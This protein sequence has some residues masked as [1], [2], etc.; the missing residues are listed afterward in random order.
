M[1]Y[2][3][4]FELSVTHAYY[5]DARCP[6]FVIEAS[7][8]TARLLKNHRLM[9]KPKPDG[10]KVLA[11]VDDEGRLFLPLSDTAEFVFSL[12]LQNPDFALFTDLTD[13]TGE[14]SLRFSNATLG[15]GNTVLLR[16]S[17]LET[18]TETLV[19]V[20]P[21]ENEPFMLGGRPLKASRLEDF[22]VSGGGVVTAY[23]A[24]TKGVII[25]TRSVS[26]GQVFTVTYP[27][28]PRTAR[29]I[30]AEVAI[31]NND[32]L[33]G[34]D[35]ALLNPPVFQIAFSAK[36]ARWTYYCVTDLSASQGA[37]GIEDKTAVVSDRLMF[38]ERNRTELQL[39]PDPEDEIDKTLQTQYPEARRIRFYSD[40]V[41]PCR[42]AAHKHLE[43]RIGDNALSEA[44]PNPS[45]KNHFKINV[46]EGDTAKQEAALFQVLKYLTV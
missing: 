16:D 46:V 30:F 35:Q 5:A 43:F 3:P 7:E 40:D 29:G 9:L 45:F 26:P 20:I 32:S 18:S 15:E 19:S 33:P 11:S 10:M 21:A 41:V 27:V 1:K 22:Q 31:R 8:E 4:L 37:F 23:D 6:D 28:K 25:D 38:S 13:F 24:E 2:R 12:R 44:L 14:N 36:R 42:Q 17:R 34:K 39:E